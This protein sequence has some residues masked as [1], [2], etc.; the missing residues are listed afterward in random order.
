MSYAKLQWTYKAQKAD[1][2]L[3]AGLDFGY[4]LKLNKLV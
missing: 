4:D 2:S 3:E 1:G